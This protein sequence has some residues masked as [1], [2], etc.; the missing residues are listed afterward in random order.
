[1]FHFI[2]VS[3]S[4][5]EFNKKTPGISLGLLICMNFNFVGSWDCCFYDGWFRV[6]LLGESTFP[7]QNVYFFFVKA[8]H[9][10]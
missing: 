5:V 1:M 6:F 3:Y 9:V 8:F 2:I 7:K 4:G 10:Q